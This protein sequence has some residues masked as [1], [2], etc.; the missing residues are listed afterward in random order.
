M[1]NE[2]C[3][4]HDCCYAPTQHQ[5]S[6]LFSSASIVRRVVLLMVIVAAARGG[7]RVVVLRYWLAVFLHQEGADVEALVLQFL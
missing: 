4:I 7:E 5:V 1:V 6:K 2:L 3:Q